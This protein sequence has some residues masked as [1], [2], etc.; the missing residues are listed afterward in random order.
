VTIAAIAASGVAAGLAAPGLHDV[1][2]ARAIVE[3]TRTA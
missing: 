1:V 2:H 3:S